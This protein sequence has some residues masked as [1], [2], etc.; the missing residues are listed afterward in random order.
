MRRWH[1]R[2][3]RP[4]PWWPENE[5]WP[6][7]DP[8]QAWRRTRVRFV[9]RFVLLALL[10]MVMGLSG[11][12]SLGWWAM[13]SLAGG[14]PP[15]PRIVFA[16]PLFALSAVCLFAFVAMMRGVAGPLGNLIEAADRVATGN[17]S[18][19]VPECGP[20]S[21]R[22][23]A[24][25]FNTMTMRLEEQDRQRK[26][27]MADIAHELRTPLTVMQG[28]LEGILDGVYPRTDE[29]LESVIDETRV[30]A[31]LVEDLRTIALSESGGLT[32]Q[33]EPTDVGGLLA[34]A[35]NGFAAQ[36]ASQHV[37]LALD[38]PQDLPIV[39]LDPVRIREVVSNLLSNAL[40]H[41]PAEGRV[42]ASAAADDGAVRVTVSDTGSG[43]ERAALD[44][45]FD[46]F[47]KG[48]GSKGSGLGL[49]IARSLVQAH[50]GRI[51]AFSEPGKGTRIEFTV[52]A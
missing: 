12:L 32:L 38:V 19:R 46:R 23:L 50:G 49:A 35:A 31:R 33:K 40:R 5:P 25:A 3:D 15:A 26:Q 36:A 24:R 47:Y 7:S 11:I 10:V 41:T 22:S 39:D 8:S 9:R 28:R 51:E 37:T 21:V 30:L 16:G 1:R 13:Q 4:P 52:P 18:G 45:I 43:I 27:L 20:R 6:P 42:T 17:F 29:Q 2:W 34:D 14:H 44:R 48:E